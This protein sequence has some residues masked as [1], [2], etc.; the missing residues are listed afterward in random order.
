MQAKQAERKR[1]KTPERRPARRAD[2]GDTCD[3]SDSAAQ[4]RHEQLLRELRSDAVWNAV[5]DRINKAI[6]K[7]SLVLSMGDIFRFLRRKRLVEIFLELAKELEGERGADALRG[8]PLQQADSMAAIMV[9][10]A[11]ADVPDDMRDFVAS[12]GTGLRLTQAPQAPDMA[13][14]TVAAAS[15]ANA[16]APGQRESWAV[17]MATMRRSTCTLSTAPDATPLGVLVDEGAEMNV[18]TQAALQ[19][20]ATD[21]AHGHPPLAQS[22]PDSQPRL[23]VLDAPMAIQAF[24]GAGTKCLAIARLHLRLGGAVYDCDCFVVQHAPA[25]VVLGLPFRTRFCRQMPSAL[26]RHAEP[27]WEVNR[28]F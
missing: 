16:A 26:L 15:A 1:S 13:Y 19:R 8:S 21:F 25:D 7:S 14:S 22:H 27:M 23:L 3:V 6:V 11:K 9:E 4:L 5:P 20:A 24:N 10:Q 2:Q 18:I 17:Q 12:C 28:L